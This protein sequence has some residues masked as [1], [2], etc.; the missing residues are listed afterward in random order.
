M[1]SG[2]RV[3]KRLEDCF[4]C[5]IPRTDTPALIKK[6]NIKECRGRLEIFSCKEKL[7]QKKPQRKD[8][9]I[10]YGASLL[11][12]FFSKEN[13]GKE[14]QVVSLFPS[15]YMGSKAPFLLERKAAPKESAWNSHSRRFL[16]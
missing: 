12:L 9:V 15:G 11:K 1:L 14:R 13:L 16:I 7:Y 3:E 10:W 4:L 2:S 6:E 5:I 8:W